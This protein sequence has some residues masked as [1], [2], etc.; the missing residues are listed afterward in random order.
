MFA[1]LRHCQS[2]GAVKKLDPA[3]SGT[4]SVLSVHGSLHCTE[5]GYLL[6]L[7]Q[8]YCKFSLCG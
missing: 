1:V 3:S 7:M 2:A 5:L 8:L 6:E 4:C